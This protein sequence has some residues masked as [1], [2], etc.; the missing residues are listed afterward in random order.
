MSRGAPNVSEMAQK[1]P[2]AAAFLFR[3]IVPPYT[4]PRGSN[5]P[6][7]IHTQHFTKA[8]AN[9]VIDILSDAI[10]IFDVACCR[11]AIDKRAGKPRGK[12]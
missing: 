2:P 4:T 7:R 11:R 10:D 12:G 5:N 3:G 1:R 9:A 8:K 6:R